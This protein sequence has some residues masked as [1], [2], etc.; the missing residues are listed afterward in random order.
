LHARAL[1]LP[2]NKIKIRVP[3]VKADSSGRI[4]ACT[5]QM[6]IHHSVNQMERLPITLKH[7]MK[8]KLSS[9]GIKSDYML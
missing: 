1:A 9:G 4:I 3:Q 2:E 8:E 7:L 5:R 6:R